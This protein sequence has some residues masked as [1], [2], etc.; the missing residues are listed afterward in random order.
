MM[1]EHVGPKTKRLRSPSGSRHRFWD[2][3]RVGSWRFVSP[4]RV[5]SAAALLAT[6]FIVIGTAG[7][8]GA[9]ATKATLTI[10]MVATFTGSTSFDGQA[11]QAG[12]IPATYEINAAGGVLGHK[13]KCLVV[14]TRGDPVDAVPAVNKLLTNSKNLVAVIG[15]DGNTAAA[16][17]PIITRAKIPLFTTAGETMFDHETSP[18]F[19]RNFPSTGASGEAMTAYA[20]E[21]GYKK[22]A[23]LFGNSPAAQAIVP[24]VLRGAKRLGLKVV[25]N[26]S[27]APNSTTYDTEVAKLISSHAQ[28]LITTTDPQTGATFYRD[29]LSKSSHIIP[30]IG[31]YNV[32]TPAFVKLIRPI[33]GG[34]RY[35]Q[36]ATAVNTYTPTKQKGYGVWVKEADATKTQVSKTIFTLT[37]QF[38]TT[39]YDDV[40]VMA[41]AMN[42]A[43]STTPTAFDRRVLS[44]F[45]GSSGATLVDSYAE[46]IRALKQGKR[47]R[48]DGAEGLQTLD[49][50]HNT[51]GLFNVLERSSSGKL[52]TRG[53]VNEKYLKSAST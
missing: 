24:G 3:A 33:L 20:K 32:V 28:V 13:L 51:A 42:E 43:H 4:L 2:S 34:R 12:C 9:S 18:Y 26:Q 41:L 7:V 50:W 40:M 11:D 45:N 8:S 30:F 15:P 21:R 10:A 46:G 31:P 14:D 36:L 49:R 44:V 47:I 52:V 25:S 5:L 1:A 23:L 29:Y 17:V 48:W 22:I 38:N 37:L 53:L 35:S 16:L 39:P 19:W 27:I 6:V